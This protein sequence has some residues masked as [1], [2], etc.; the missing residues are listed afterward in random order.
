MNSMSR[1]ARIALI[2]GIVV[3]AFVPLLGS[4]AAFYTDFLWFVDL[5]H[6]QVFMTRITSSIA[7]GIAFGVL[8]FVLLFVNARIARR[9]APRAVL[10]SVG[11]MPPQFEELLVRLRTQLGPIIDQLVL[12]GS[13][14]IA[15]AVG[16]GMAEHWET[17]RLAFSGVRFGADDA[18]FGRDIGFFVFSLPALRLVAS[19]LT[20]M[21]VGVV[22]VTLV[23]HLVDGAIQPLVRFRGF[24]PHV[25][26]HLSVL[27]AAIVASKAFD[28][29]LDIWELDFSPRGQVTG[30]SFTDIHAQL[31]AYWILIVIAVASALLLLANIRFKGWR[32]PA[33]ALGVWI[34]AS[35]LVGAVYPGIIQALRVRPN[36]LAAETPYIERNIAATR[37]AFGLD[38]VETREFPADESLTAREVLANEDTLDNVRLWDPDIVAQSYAQLQIIRPYYHFVDADIDR[39]VVDGTRRQVLV[40]AREMDTGQLDPQAQNWVNQHLVYTHGYGMVM[41]PVNGAD[42]RGFPE[43]IIGNIPPRS[44]TDVSMTQPAIYFGE[45][46]TDYAI[47]KTSIGEFD[48][49]V[50]ES[51]AET[52]YSGEGGVNI[53]SFLNRVAFALRFASTQILFS[54]YIKADSTVLFDRDIRT[55]VEKLVPWLWLD[56]DAYP[57]LANGRLVWIIDGY[58]WTNNYPYSERHDG[59]NYMRNSVKVTVDS[60]DGTVT[61]YRFDDQDPIIE[62]WGKVFPELLTDASE[63]PDEIRDHVRYPEDFFS[64]QA[65]VYKRYHMT[66]PR[67]FFNKEDLWQLPGESDGMPME[68]FYVLTR[69]PAATAEAFEMIMPFTASKRENMIGWM[70]ANSDPQEYGKRVVYQFPKERVILGPEQVKSRINQDETISPQLTLWSQRGSQVIFGNMLVIPLEQSIIYIQPLYLQ[71]ERTAMPELTRVLVVYSDRVEMAADLEQALLA[72]FGEQPAEEPTGTPEPGA[73]A[74]VAAAREIYERAIEAQKSGN[75]AEYGRLIDELGHILSALAG[76]ASVEATPT[77]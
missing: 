38:D 26:A 59:I 56:N 54:D 41:S 61:F 24:A 15:V 29:W 5:G 72:V 70:A 49:P 33:I 58:T 8:A 60:I 36:E 34:A 2:V 68:P 40:S 64:V 55:R 74:D 75:W 32:L 9:M 27:L 14:G 19:W 69:L 43:F 66:N 63:M 73:A 25:K 51:N 1:S 35:I 46:T 22:V 6:Q 52:T 44:S 23:V 3:F 20:Q 21:L 71:S 4:L 39:Y 13:I 53:G 77:P 11:D 50:G 17:F 31:P 76:D 10:T 7:T 30:A 37:E 67:V 62:A 45:A 65:E 42:S 12:W 47:V 16:L 48:Y 18:Q 28:Y 57:V